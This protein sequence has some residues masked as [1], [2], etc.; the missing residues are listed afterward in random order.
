MVSYGF[1]AISLP[2]SSAAA[3]AELSWSWVSL[4]IESVPMVYLNDFRGSGAKPWSL[5]SGF[6]S[7]ELKEVSDS[8]G[9]RDF[10]PSG[11]GMMMLL[12][13]SSGDGLPYSLG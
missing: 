7:I 2:F 9:S 5:S 8:S 10:I 4:P 11:S 1:I 6:A 12:T 13:G 3:L